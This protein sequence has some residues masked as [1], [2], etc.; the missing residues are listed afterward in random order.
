[1]NVLSM[2]TRYPGFV[3]NRFL[4]TK[5][6]NR[7]II[8][9]ISAELKTSD[10]A[11]NIK[12]TISSIA[13]DEVDFD[14]YEQLESSDYDFTAGVPPSVSTIER[15]FFPVLVICVTAAATILFFAIRTK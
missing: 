4:G 11:V 6:I 2:E 10:G 8:V 14:N 7:N 3:K 5:T 15:I 9:N 12:D 1:L 13:A